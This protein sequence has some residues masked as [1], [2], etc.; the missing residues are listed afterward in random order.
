MLLLSCH[1]ELW[2]LAY[3]VV[4]GGRSVRVRLLAFKPPQGIGSVVPLVDGS[5]RLGSGLLVLVASTAV[6]AGCQYSNPQ[7]RTVCVVRTAVTSI[8][9]AGGA[10]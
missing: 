7:M 3:D 5:S 9:L 6:H 4:C 10:L 2:L 1:A 8:A